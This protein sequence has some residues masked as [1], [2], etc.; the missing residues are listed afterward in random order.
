MH[1]GLGTYTF[2]WN[3]MLS[4]SN[5]SHSFDFRNMLKFTEDN[6]IR[7]FQFGD[8]YPLHLLT[9]TELAE[10]KKSAVE[11]N[12]QVQVG[13]RGLHVEQTKN[14]L[15]LAAEFNAPFLRVVTDDGDY[16]P[17]EN[18]VIRIIRELLPFLKET[19]IVLAIENHDRFT[20]KTLASIVE[21]TDAASVAICL[22][23]TNSFGVGESIGEIAPVLLPYT[24]NLHIKDFNVTRADHKMG[25]SITGAAAG[26]GM[27]NIPGLLNQASHYK[28]CS[29][30]TLEI[31]M[32]EEETPQQTIAK[33]MEMVTESI[34]YLKKYIS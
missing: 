8:N 7:F 14:Y 4:G 9:K 15:F 13:T 16:L 26:K 21:Q 34:K 33:E 31:W 27:L 5:P 22:D 6:N 2:P 20:A 18:E 24:V 32:N 3:I 12:I 1:F 25:F 29:T 11:K 10:L 30:A 17:S 28:R 19:G 23:T